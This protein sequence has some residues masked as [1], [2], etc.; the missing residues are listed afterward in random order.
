MWQIHKG[1]LVCF[2]YSYGSDT[3]L[4]LA[5]SVQPLSYYHFHE[6]NFLLGTKTASRPSNNSFVNQAHISKCLS[7]G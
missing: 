6:M 7:V 4:D 3:S 5:H 2:F 1:Y